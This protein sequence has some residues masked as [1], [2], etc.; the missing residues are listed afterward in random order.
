MTDSDTPV[1]FGVTPGV[2]NGLRDEWAGAVAFMAIEVLISTQERRTK[3]KGN[4]SEDSQK[5][6]R[7]RRKLRGGMAVIKSQ[8]GKSITSPI[9]GLLSQRLPCSIAHVFFLFVFI[10]IHA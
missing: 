5:I 9:P 3:K 4:Y 10:Y 1:G 8:K 6:I 2:R 7:L